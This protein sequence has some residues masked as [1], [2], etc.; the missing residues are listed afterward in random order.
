[1]ELFIGERDILFTMELEKLIR[2]F[3]LQNAVQYGGKVNIGSVLGKVLSASPELRNRVDE[4]RKKISEEAKKVEKLGAAEQEKELEK[5][6]QDIFEKKVEKVG[7]EKLPELKNVTGKVVMRMAPNPNGPAHIG[8]CRMAILNDEYVKRHKGTLIL[9]FDDTD[10][11]NENKLPMKEAYKWIEEDL[12]WLGVDFHRVERASARLDVYYKYF[13]QILE[14]G[15]AY[16]C[17][18]KQE[19]WSDLVRKGGGSCPCRKLAV[20]ENLDRWKKMLSG[21]FKEGQAV[22]RMKTHG[23]DDPAVREWVTFRIVDAPQHPFAD[24]KLKVWPMLDFASAIDDFD[25]GI[26]H[27]IRG[28]DLIVSEK[29]QR[30]LYEYMGWKYPETRVYGKFI[31]TEEM[32]ISKSKVLAGIKSGLYTGYDD[33][34]LVFLRALKRRG[35]LPQAIRNYMLNLGLNEAETTVD[36]EILFSE[37]RKLID[38]SADRYMV[39]LDPE[40]V[41]ISE[42]LK[43]SNLKYAEIKYHPDKEKTRKIGVQNKVF[44]SGDDLKNFKGK[45]VRLIDLFNILVGQKAKYSKEQGFGFDTKKIQWVA[46]DDCVK[47]KLVTPEGVKEGVGEIGLLKLKPDTIIQMLRI[48]FGRIDFVGKDSITIYFGHK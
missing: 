7:A 11:K 1:M 29:R 30:V 37:N 38:K 34:K 10:P 5:V 33:P 32:V 12:K 22:G 28:K 4:I 2:S 8:H 39:V 6:D 21:K 36:L 23:E 16:V 45:D 18:C 27:I 17:T 31:T 48:G 26:T 14:K 3:C 20:K 24:K 41:D 44:V 9:R 13:G 35:I 19:E 15:F 42:P 47:V 25:F 46:T 40:Q 43:K